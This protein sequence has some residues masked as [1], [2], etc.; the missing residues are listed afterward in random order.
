[1]SEQQK[2]KPNY[3][4]RRA[5]VIALAAV[6]AGGIHAGVDTY[7]NTQDQNRKLDFFSQPNLADHLDTIPKGYLKITVHKIDSEEGTPIKVAN[8]LHAKDT[9]LVAKL[10]S[11]QV[12]G[13]GDMQAS[14][15]VVVPDDL[16]EQPDQ[17]V[18]H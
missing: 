18:K 12:G 1:M 15:I 17:S 7:H 6:A 11:K 5:G 4:L 14:E 13:P 10:I 16:L 2:T 9:L 8:N 3:A